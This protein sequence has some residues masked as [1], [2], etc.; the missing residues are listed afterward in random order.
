MGACRWPSVS[1]LRQ[2]LLP[3]AAPQ[4]TPPQGLVKSNARADQ[5]LGVILLSEI[6]RTSPERRRE[7]LYY[8]ALG[9]YR[10]GN[11]SEARR[12]NDRLLEAEPANLQAADLRSMIDDRVAREG[13]VGVAI[14]GGVAVAGVVGGILLRNLGRKR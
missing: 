14:V 8:L 9:N 3:P 4:L 12:Y 1:V 5:Q 6:F 13:L 11:Y 2:R 10:L 7:C